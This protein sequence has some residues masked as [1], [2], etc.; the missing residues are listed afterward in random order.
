M[1]LTR[2][3]IKA[4]CKLEPDFTEED[5]LLDLIGRAVQTRTETFLNRKLYAPDSEIPESDPDGLHLPD[6]IKI[7]MLLLAT[8]YYENRSAVSD[9][10]KA[11]LPMGFLWNVQPYRYIPL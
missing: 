1:L 7:G 11:S 4:Q 8:H 5:A 3:E 9:F 2:E 6:D 10:E